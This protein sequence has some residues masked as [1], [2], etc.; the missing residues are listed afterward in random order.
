MKKNP[1]KEKNKRNREYLKI[2]KKRKQSRK[3]KDKIK[4][5][6]ET[7]ENKSIEVKTKWEERQEFIKTYLYV[8]GEQRDKRLARE[9]IDQK[10]KEE[11]W[12]DSGIL[13]KLN[14]EKYTSL[15]K[16]I[17]KYEPLNRR[18]PKGRER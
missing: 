9:E 14:R 3:K 18:V 6:K 16:G 15:Y 10:K 13:P 8:I 1:K 4:E 2:L 5:I 17:P 12:K 7:E 11:L